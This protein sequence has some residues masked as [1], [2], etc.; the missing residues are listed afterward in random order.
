MD[1]VP[2]RRLDGR[3]SDRR[4]DVLETSGGPRPAAEPLLRPPFAPVTA[5]DR[6][7]PRPA[8]RSKTS[9][10]NRPAPSGKSERRVRLSP[11]RGLCEDASKGYLPRD[12]RA[13][14]GPRTS[15]WRAPHHSGTD[16]L[17]GTSRNGS[18]GTRTRDL[19]RD[20]PAVPQLVSS[21]CGAPPVAS[22]FTNPT[23][24]MRFP[25]SP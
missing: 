14:I 10:I 16:P 6:S 25:G 2:L 22:H 4:S 21:R 18:D 15:R 3:G 9:E 19:R 24:L 17:A 23:E 12:V 1:R 5:L 13:M 8:S 7:G 20:R 11:Q